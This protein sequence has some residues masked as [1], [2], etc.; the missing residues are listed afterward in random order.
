MTRQHLRLAFVLHNPKG[1]SGLIG[2]ILSAA[3]HHITYYCPLN[4][5][6]LPAQDDFDAAVV[7]GGKMSANDHDDLPELLQELLWIRQTVE[8]KKPFLGICL[9]AQLLA[10]TFGGQVTRHPKRLTEI[11]YYRIYP[12]I[13]GYND[14]FANIPERFFQWHNEGFTIPDGGIKLAESDLYPNQ[15]FKI[16]CC[17]Y[18]FQFHPEATAEQIRHWHTRDKAEL[19]H[20]GAQTVEAQRRYFEQLSPPIKQWLE[21][22]LQQWLYSSHHQRQT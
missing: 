15:A 17:A 7:F 2:E 3:G 6:P 21:Q 10:M 18:G 11:G 13:A 20:P 5:E 8:L 19:E 16:G 22:F 1:C 14:I 4:G 12:T 9:G